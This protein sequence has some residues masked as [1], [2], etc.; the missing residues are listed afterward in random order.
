MLDAD[1]LDD[2]LREIDAEEWTSGAYGMSI[3][4]EPCGFEIELDCMACPD[5]GAPS[6]LFG[7]I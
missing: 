3:I 2:V 4:H 1:I 6:P 5:C 7:L